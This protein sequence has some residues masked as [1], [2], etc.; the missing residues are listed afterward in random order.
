MVDVFHYTDK[1]GWNGIRAQKAWCFE[2]KKPKDPAR[3]FGAYFTDIPP[4]AENLRTLHK[5]IRVPKVKQEFC[6]WFLETTGLK[7]HNGGRGRDKRIYYSPTDYEVAE[8]RQVAE[9]PVG[10]IREQY[11]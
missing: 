8:D 1:D 2:A 11:E 4:T 6:F 5:K 3:P 9:G 10:E 7:Q